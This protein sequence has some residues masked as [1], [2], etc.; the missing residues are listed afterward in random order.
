MARSFSIKVEEVTESLK[1]TQRTTNKYRWV[2]VGL[3]IDIAMCLEVA[4]AEE[5]NL[6]ERWWQLVDVLTGCVHPEAAE[7]KE[8]KET[9]RWRG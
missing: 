8:G 1:E 7:N 6:K 4:N 2:M 3:R 9:N 5:Q